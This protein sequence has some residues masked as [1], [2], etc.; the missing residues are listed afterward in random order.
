MSDLK[1][2]VEDLIERIYLG[3]LYDTPEDIDDGEEASVDLLALITEEREPVGWRMSSNPEMGW[4]YL[5]GADP[6]DEADG[7]WAVIQPLYTKPPA[8]DSEA[9]RDHRAMER[10]R[11]ALHEIFV[12]HPPGSMA[13]LRA[14]HGLGLD[15]TDRTPTQ[16]EQTDD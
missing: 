15:A 10:M 6:P 9:E 4:E 5:E 14:K 3:G 11:Q 2:R 12:N 1:A 8:P 16:E 7:F 13:F